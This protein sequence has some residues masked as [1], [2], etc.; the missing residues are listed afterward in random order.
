MCNI[1]KRSLVS[2]LST[3]QRHGLANCGCRPAQ[4]RAKNCVCFDAVLYHRLKLGARILVES[5]QVA[6]CKSCRQQKFF[7]K[8]KTISTQRAKQWHLLLQT[9]CCKWNTWHTIL[10][11]VWLASNMDQPFCV[12]AFACGCV[13]NGRRPIQKPLSQKLCNFHETLTK[14]RPHNQKTSNVL[15]SGWCPFLINA[16]FLAF[17]FLVK[18]WPELLRLQRAELWLLWAYKSCW[19]VKPRHGK[20]FRVYRCRQQ[21]IWLE[22]LDFQ[23]C[24]CKQN[25]NVMLVIMEQHLN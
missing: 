19:E 8:W 2:G 3:N 5:L 22:F 20:L 7:I 24:S 11:F 25:M 14:N 10:L 23:W 12:K 13:A 15:D 16:H 17:L 9:C 4:Q 6:L 18:P 1:K 21:A